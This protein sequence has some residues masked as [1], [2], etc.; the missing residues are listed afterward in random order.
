MAE[1]RYVTDWLQLDPAMGEAIRAFWRRE[2]A[3]VEGERATQRLNEVVAHVLDADGELAAVSTATPKILPRLGQPLYYYR[4]FV[5][6]QWRSS[7]LV[8]PLLRHTQEVLEDH[9]RKNNYP[10]IGVL[11]ELENEGFADT[12]RWA[13]WPGVGF[14]FIGV[15]PRGLELRVRYFR[16]AKLKT[17]AEVQALLRQH[18][19]V[20]A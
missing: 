3:N 10:C 9:A 13:Q 7:K 2:Q 14:S 4:C 6:K 19:Q 17:P 20:A 18:K 12:L 1:Y 15:S 8:R 11:L 16:G 5:G